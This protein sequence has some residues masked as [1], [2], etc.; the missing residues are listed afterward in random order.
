[1][2]TQV[3]MPQ[4]GESV[5]EG[6]V[7]KWLKQEG[8][9][10]ERNE[11]LLEVETDKVT[12]EVSAIEGGTLLKV[13][14]PEGQTVR[15]GT[16]LALIGQPGEPIPT[17][18]SPPAPPLPKL[19]ERG[20]GGEGRGERASFV[21]P[22]VARIAAEHNVDVSQVKGTGQ[23]GRVTKQDILAYVE[24][25][26][27]AQEAAPPKKEALPPWEQ[28]G[29]GELFRPSEEVFGPAVAPAPG[30]PAA[31]PAPAPAPLPTEVVPLSNMRKAIAE[32]MVR[33]KHTSP[34]VTTIFEIDMSRVV[35]HRERYKAAYE[36]DGVK[37]T[38][39]VYFVKA[40]VHALKAYPL[41]NSSFSDE[42]LIVKRQINIGIAVSLGDEGLIVPVIKGADNL[43]LLGVARA[44]NDLAE[45]A[46]NHQLKPDD[47]QGGTFTITNHGV[48]G[49]LFATPIINQP[50][51]A[52][53]G[54]GAL[55]KRVVVVSQ[56]GVD[57]IAIRPMV[58]VG[59]TF[60]HRI[61]DGVGADAFVAKIKEVL[62]NWQDM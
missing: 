34:H 49:S 59:L 11:P 42:G 45:R 38:Y 13:Y 8:Q 32:H 55:Q 9:P 23:G 15:A 29:L 19:G 41:V 62:E 12:T 28:P 37:L 27:K 54:V 25:R 60:D 30:R 16:L 14:V 36:R 48:S 57:A 21:S 22:V 51:A 56:D 6:K 1:M 53:L 50:Q 24:A 4:L 10:V 20:W 31:P 47:V 5:V 39:T 17:T 58:Y 52:I 2:A 3:V 18:P 33:S 40:A 46:R 35:A 44:V 26:E 61:L 7:T 43:N